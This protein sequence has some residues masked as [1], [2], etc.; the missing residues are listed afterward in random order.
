MDIACQKWPRQQLIK[1]VQISDWIYARID[2]Q[3]PIN[4]RVPIYL[5]QAFRSTDTSTKPIYVSIG[6][7]LSLET[8]L[9][10]CKLCCKYRI[11]EPIR[12]VEIKNILKFCLKYISKS[13]TLV[14]Q[15]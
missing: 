14:A 11:P 1:H 3:P 4:L 7:K 5:F 10:I 2:V 13:F 15:K 8:A 12:Q 9:R 6:H